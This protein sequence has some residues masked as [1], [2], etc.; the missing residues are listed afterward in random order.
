M[1]NGIDVLTSGDSN[2]GVLA[3]IAH[4]DD[5]SFVY[6]GTLWKLRKR[7]PEIPIG[8]LLI[9]DGDYE[10]IKAGK[11]RVEEQREE[12]EILGVDT[13]GRAGLPDG[14]FTQEMV[15]Y[16]ADWISQQVLQASAGGIRFGTVLTFGPEGFTGHDDH[17]STYLA[18]VQAAEYLESIG[19]FA[20]NVWGPRMSSGERSMWPSDY[21]VPIPPA[22]TNGCVYV[23]IRGDALQRKIDALKAHR[24]QR[25]NGVDRQIDIVQANPQE[26]WRLWYRSI[27]GRVSSGNVYVQNGN[28]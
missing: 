26:Y 3:V 5:G 14:R 28:V 16:V 11:R 22:N 9:T 7:S 18:T 20:G 23:D 25:N 8:V 19:V 10:G 6:A 27:G 15:P 12:N 4:P 24:S 17:K 13:F 2:N 21:F 1:L